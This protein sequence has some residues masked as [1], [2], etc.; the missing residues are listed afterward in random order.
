LFAQ[1]FPALTSRNFRLFLAG[2]FVSLIGSWMQSTI[3]P[4]LAY[5]IT[6]QPI[7]LGLLGFASSLP[8][9]FLM[10]P[11]GV[12]VERW[13]KRRTV[14]VMQVVLMAQA[15]VL[16]FLALSGRIT[17]VHIISLSFIAGVASSLEITARQAMIAELAGRDSLPNAIALNSTIFNAARV[18]GP[19]L[20]APFLILLKNQ[21]SGW[22]FF[23]NG[24]SFLFVILSLLLMTTRSEIHVDR[25]QNTLLTDFLEGQKFIRGSALVMLIIALVSIFSFFGFP[26]SQQIP[27][28]AKDVLHVA[29][30]TDAAVATRNSILVTAQGV[31]ALVAAVTLAAYSTIRRKGLVMVAGQLVF[32]AGLL[33]MAFSRSLRLSVVCI[34]LVGWGTIIQLALANTL[35]QLAVPDA[36]R[37]RVISTYFWAQM[38]AAPFGSLFIGWLAQTRGAQLAVGV[39]GAI[40]LASALLIHTLRPVGLKATGVPG[41][42]CA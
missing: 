26:Y 5:Q 33:G 3:L 2:Q 32:A 36:L 14:I 7:Y 13:D 37:G 8:A 39:G 4:F 20:T 24:V 35:I 38:G 22:A 6:N 17:I 31:G 19:S 12:Y 41:E 29:G 18:I 28:F 21:G 27:V 25:A 11:M 40:C 15:F 1:R 10:L 34:A 16:A 42:E 9:L 23:A 30:D